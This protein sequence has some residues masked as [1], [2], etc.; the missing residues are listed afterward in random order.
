MAGKLVLIMG[1][2]GVGKSVILKKLRSSHPEFHFPR[3]ATTR[4]QRE[5]EGA[6]L[7]HFLNDEEFDEL[8]AQKKILEFARVHGGGRY[9]TLVDEIIPA[10]KQGKTVIREV[11]VQ[12]FQSIQKNPLFSGKEAPYKLQSIFILPETKEQLITHITKRAPMEQSELKRRLESMEKELSYA[13]GC[14]VQIT[15]QE[16]NLDQTIEKVEDFIAR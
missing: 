14:D 9:G 8:I 2:S 4:P 16:G 10:I 11:D 7:Y 1:P 3:S 15:N 5:A 6:E 12:G 13:N